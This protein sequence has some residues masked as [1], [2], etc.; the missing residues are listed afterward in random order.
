MNPGPELKRLHERLQNL[1]MSATPRHWEN[2]YAALERDLA[3]A[4]ERE[5]VLLDA[6]E[7]SVF[8]QSHYAKLL[9]GWDE[10]ERMQFANAAAWLARLAEVDREGKQP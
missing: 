4:R 6:L 9:N 3:A 2:R 8:H 7:R 10:G 1:G 5:R